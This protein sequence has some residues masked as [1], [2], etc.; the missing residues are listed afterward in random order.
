MEDESAMNIAAFQVR[1]DTVFLFSSLRSYERTLTAEKKRKKK[2]KKSGDLSCWIVNI[3]NY[4]GHHDD[5]NELR[6]RWLW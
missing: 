4:G 1:R 2:R 6:W 3:D 5:D